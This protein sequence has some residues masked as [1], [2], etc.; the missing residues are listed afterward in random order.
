MNV[1][2]RRCV[3]CA[4]VRVAPSYYTQRKTSLLNGVS[5]PKPNP[6]TYGVPRASHGILKKPG[7]A[8]NKVLRYTWLPNSTPN[9]VSCLSPQLFSLMIFD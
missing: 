6:H 7:I 1:A 2:R 9:G 4:Q 5:T 3:D 8:S